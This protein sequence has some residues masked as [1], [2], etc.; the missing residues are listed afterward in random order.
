MTSQLLFHEPAPND[1]A[2]VFGLYSDPLVWGP[3]PLSRHDSPAQTARAI[4]IWRGGWARDGHGMWVV[5][6]ADGTFVGIGGAF[7]RYD[8]AWNL[9]F[10]LLPRFWGRGY[11]QRISGAARDAAAASR[12]DLPVTAYLLEGNDRSQRTVERAG[13]HRVWRGPDAGNPDPGAIRLLYADR[14]IGPAVVRALTDF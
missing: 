12:P 1:L 5:R 3:D 4:D 10:R 7:V 13:L 2:E 14:A 9:G 8:V 11:A 6:H